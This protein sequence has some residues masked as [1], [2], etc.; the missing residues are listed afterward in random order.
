MFTFTRAAPDATFL[1]ADGLLKTATTNVP[2]I[3]Y[4]QGGVCLGLL[5]EASKQNIALN[6]ADLSNG[7]W[8]KSDCTIS[9]S[10]SIDGTTRNIRI[11]ENS[12]SAIHGVVAGMTVTANTTY[13][14]SAIVSPQGR[15]FAFL[16]GINTDQFGAVFDFVNLTSA[17]IISGTSTINQRGIIPFGNGKFLIWVSGVLNAASTTLNF[18]GG[19]ATSLSVPAGYTYLGDGASGINMEYI[20]VELGSFPTSR[21]PTAGSAVTRAADS[22]TRALGAEFSTTTGT[23]SASAKFSAG[24]APSPAPTLV[25]FNDGT[26]GK[27]ILLNR[28]SLADTIKLGI[29]DTVIQVNSDGATLANSALFKIAAAWEVNNASVVVNGGAIVPDTVGTIPTG[30]T[31]MSVGH[32]SPSANSQFSGHIR[33]LRYYPTR[34]SDAFLVR[35]ST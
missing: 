2:R 7:T 10:T 14:I 26:T 20:Q 31:T 17:Q 24:Q 33:V 8:T 12:A 30:L 23:L 5:M 15:Q 22:C 16:Y 4:G 6:N 25:A 1:G 34:E 21:I 18:V 11:V 9:S 29:V 13:C 27:T 35:E 19:P 3:E 32:Q 28:G